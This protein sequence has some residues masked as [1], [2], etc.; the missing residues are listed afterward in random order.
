M[1]SESRKT[2]YGSPAFHSDESNTDF[3]SLDLIK[4]THSGREERKDEAN[5]LMVNLMTLSG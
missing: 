2:A 5:T 1:L 3:T 4:Q